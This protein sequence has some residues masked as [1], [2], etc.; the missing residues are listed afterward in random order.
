VSVALVIQHAKRMHYT[1]LPTVVFH[2]EQYFSTL[3]HNW[4][5]Y[6]KKVV[7]HRMCT[8]IS[9]TV[10]VRNISHRKENSATYYH[11]HTYVSCKVPV[12]LVRF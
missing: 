11:K 8:L 12:I 9:S 3:S 10:F 7:G 2:A 5:N 6:W 4:H 1:I